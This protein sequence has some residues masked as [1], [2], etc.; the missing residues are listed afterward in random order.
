VQ[1]SVGGGFFPRLREDGDELY[2]QTRAGIVAV[3]LSWNPAPTPGE[4]RLLFELTADLPLGFDVSADGQRF[5]VVELDAAVF[6][7][8]RIEIVLDW[9]RELETLVRGS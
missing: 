1:L 7:A 4:P 9:A 8:G 6:D 5:Y 2:Y 3:P